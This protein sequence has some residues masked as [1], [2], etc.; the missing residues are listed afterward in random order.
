[1]RL[2]LYFFFLTSFLQL[3]SQSGFTDPFQNPVILQHY[4]AQELTSIR[5]TDSVK[6]NTI[7]YYYTQSFTLEEVSC[8]CIP[9][10]PA[11]FDVSNYEYLRKK[12]V[13]YERH[14]E[15][16][17]FK[18]TLLSINELQYQLPIHDK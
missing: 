9:P 8:N 4:D 18:L 12:E 15:K 13:R 3:K 7:R 17:G 11:T 1:M 2:L 10:T 5:Q 14:F 6:F 16:Y